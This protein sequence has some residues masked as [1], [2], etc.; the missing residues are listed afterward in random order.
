MRQFI[1]LQFEKYDL[2]Q[3]L[4]HHKYL[5]FKLLLLH[6]KTPQNLLIQAD[7][8]HFIISHEFY[9]SGVQEG[10]IWALLAHDLS[11]GCSQ[12]MAG[13]RTL[14]GWTTQGLVQYCLLLIESQG[15]SMVSLPWLVW[16]SSQHGSLRAVGLLTC[17]QSLQECIF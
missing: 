12:I 8:S 14:G 1:L 4:L 10:L 6:I 16:D 2:A 7:N 17:G 13:S 11:C 15:L 9:V 3:T 5:I